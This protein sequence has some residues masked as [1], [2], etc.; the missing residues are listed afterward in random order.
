MKQ[1]KNAIHRPSLGTPGLTTG[2]NY[3]PCLASTTIFFYW[4]TADRFVCPRS[5]GPGALSRDPGRWSHSQFLRETMHL[6][7]GPDF[8]Y[9]ISLD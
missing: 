9:Y 4:S 2:N 1:R 3:I 7:F 5:Q 8:I 6:V